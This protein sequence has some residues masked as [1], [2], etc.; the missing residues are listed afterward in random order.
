[1]KKYLKKLVF[2]GISVQSAAF[3]V[4]VASVFWGFQSMFPHAA[5]AFRAV[6]ED[7]SYGWF[8]PLFSLY[9]LW[10][11]F[12][13]KL[14]PW[15]KNRADEES[16]PAQRSRFE[17]IGLFFL[18]VFFLFV[19]F[20]G[21]RGTQL[22]FE[23]VGFAGI[24]WTLS[25]IFGGWK[26]ARKTA[27]PCWF[28]LFCIPLNSYLDIVTV[29]LRLFAT[30]VSFAVLKGVG[31]DIIRQG[32][33]IGAA[34]GS[35]AID[36]AA[37]CSGLRSIF[38][39]MAL[40]AGYG[41]F[42]QR[43]FWR[44][45]VLFASSVPLAVLGNICR[46]LTIVATASWCDPDFATGFYH[47]YSG[48]VVFIVAVCC[49]LGVSALL[50]KIGATGSSR[51]ASCCGATGSSRPVVGCGAAGAATLSVFLAAFMV[52]QAHMPETVLTDA[53]QIV[54][55]ELAG[56]SGEDLPPAEAE[57]ANL[58]DDTTF[59][60]K[61]YTD[62]ATGDWYLVTCVIGGKSKR[63]IHRPEL[64]LPS[65]GFQMVNPRSRVFAGRDWRIMELER[66]YARPL[67]FAYTFF[68]QENFATSSHI[69]RIMRD[70][71]DRSLKG[72][73][74]R[75]VMVTVNSSRAGEAALGG[76]LEKLEGTLWK[77]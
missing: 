45:S 27:F 14:L 67:G 65:Q 56:F 58:P 2:G 59:V 18:L 72:R 39:L 24:L 73:F 9:V 77:K 52:W 5:G 17:A 31:A 42:A 4:A 40:A 57:I 68:N 30:S 75:W 69:S 12:G 25:W 20:I 28:L 13:K 60:K 53:P 35:F 34:D 47:D 37:P 1:M 43:K 66:G 19:G 70:I 41:Y 46:I 29:H 7:L 74:D 49:M 76:F 55:A 10:R 33:M 36:I 62:D 15:A 50:D 11:E 51:P 22:R 6:E 48:Y 21:V 23:I 61:M 32:T 26:V 54:L 38:A 71:L 44:W 63:S 16:I 3:L 8:V 64:C